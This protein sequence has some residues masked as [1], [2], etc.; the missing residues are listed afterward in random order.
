M[1]AIAH[2]RYGRPSSL[3]LRDTDMPELADD[4]V[5]VRVRAS[6]VNPADWYA[7]TGLLPARFGNGLRRP[8]ATGVG[9]DLAGVVEAV[10]KD[11]HG[12][13]SGDEVF[14]TSDSSWAQYTTARPERLARKP[15]GISFED[16]AAVPIAGITALQAL[17][18]HGQVQAGQKVL[19]NGAA[20]GVGTFSVQLAKTFGADVTAVCSTGKVDL[21]RSLGADRLIDYTQ[22]DFTRTADRHDL[23]LDIAGSR[24]FLAC[25]RVLT[26]DATVVLVGGPITYRGLGPL[27]HMAATILKSKGRSQTLKVFVAKINTDDLEIL[28]ELLEAGRIKAVIERTYPLDE[29]A[30]ALAHL[31]EGHAKAK[32]VLT[33]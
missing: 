29:A 15:A 1:K 25:R 20:G 10:G 9:R 5:L 13:Q 27:P 3:E 18:D 16:A 4:E 30:D 23:M 21:V 28:A 2:V 32:L 24:S 26:P 31:G 17:R 8:K 33:I 6:S 19:V 12:L 14:G 7:V 22:Q 11:V